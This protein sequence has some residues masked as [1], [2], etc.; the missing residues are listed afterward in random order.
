MRIHLHATPIIVQIDR[1]LEEVA[2]HRHIQTFMLRLRAVAMNGP[3]ADQLDIVP[4][5]RPFEVEMLEGAIEGGQDLL[6]LLL[7]GTRQGGIYLQ[8]RHH[9]ELDDFPGLL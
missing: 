4:E 6:L 5:A 8:D 1:L 3:K 2:L 7:V 9:H